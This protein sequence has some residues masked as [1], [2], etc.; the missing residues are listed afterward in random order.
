[1]ADTSNR[2]EAPIDT[3][4]VTA[5]GRR[6]RML[7]EQYSSEDPEVKAEAAGMIVAVCE[8]IEMM[9]STGMPLTEAQQA[10]MDIYAEIKGEEPKAA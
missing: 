3:S 4:W 2:A 6:A 5:M 1:M 7:I 10:L 9:K 8:Q